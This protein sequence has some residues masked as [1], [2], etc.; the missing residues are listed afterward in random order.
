MLKSIFLIVLT[1]VVCE[2]LFSPVAQVFPAHF[3]KGKKKRAEELDPSTNLYEYFCVHILL[4]CTLHSIIIR[5]D[6]I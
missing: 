2:Y 5:Y 6:T 4:W 1:V 3:L